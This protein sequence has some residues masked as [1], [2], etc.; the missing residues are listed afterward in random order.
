MCA[1]EP[2]YH[3]LVSS[4]QDWPTA[5]CDAIEVGDTSRCG[6][7]LMLRVVRCPPLQDVQYTYEGVRFTYS[8]LGMIAMA[9]HWF[10]MVDLAVFS[11]GLSAF[12]L[13]C[14]QAQLQKKLQNHSEQ[15][16]AHLAPKPRKVFSEIGRFLVALIFLLLT[17]GSAISVLDHT[18]FEP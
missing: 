18:Y 13:V 4:P 5:N 9:I 3:C 11:T 15:M 8:A 10:L 7:A 12:V 17:F 2:M 14:A 1:Y 16:F 6:V